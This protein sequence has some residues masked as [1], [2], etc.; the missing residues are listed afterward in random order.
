MEC[1]AK[2]ILP[3]TADRASDERSTTMAAGVHVRELRMSILLSILSTSWQLTVKSN[4][5]WMFEYH[6]KRGQSEDDEQ[7]CRVL[8]LWNK[9]ND[10]RLRTSLSLF[11]TVN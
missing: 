5:A 4:A 3:R 10:I 7:G 8:S 2:P 9:M 6:F 1:V 11:D